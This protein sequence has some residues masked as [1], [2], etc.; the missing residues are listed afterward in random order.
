MPA[1]VAS[2]AEGRTMV[3]VWLNEA[4]GLTYEVGDG[5][6]RRFVKWAPAGSEVDLDLAAEADRMEWACRYHDALPM[7]GCPF[8]W[9]AEE[10]VAAARR[11][12]GAGGQDPAA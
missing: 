6:E 9:S 3:P 8:S 1:A 11:K 4:G 7:D 12:A 2:L 10:R 5:A